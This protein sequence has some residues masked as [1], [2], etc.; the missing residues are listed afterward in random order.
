MA[1]R[2]VDPAQVLTSVPVEEPRG[3]SI[4]RCR[5]V[6]RKYHERAHWRPPAVTNAPPVARKV[7]K[8]DTI[9]GDLRQDDYAWLR[10]KDDPDVLAYL[11]AEN[12]YT[13]AVTKPTEGVR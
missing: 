5:L 7:P 2:R 9:H 3:A 1:A 10:Q 11:E 6:C 13:D 8:I 12:A 4:P